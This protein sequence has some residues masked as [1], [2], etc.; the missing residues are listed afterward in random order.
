[1]VN[2]YSTHLRSSRFV[3]GALLVLAM[4]VMTMPPAQAAP[5]EFKERYSFEDP[6]HKDDFLSDV[7]GTDIYASASGKGTVKFYENGRI[8]DHFN[9]T[10][11]HWNPATGDVVIRQEA[12]TFRGM[13]V[14]VFDPETMTV[15]IT[16]E[17]TFTGLPSKWM[18]PGEGLLW[19]D[20]GKVTFAGTIVLDVSGDEPELI[21]FD[22]TVD[23]K[24]PHPELTEDFEVLVGIL[25]GALGA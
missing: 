3:I 15:T 14:E 10:T 4:V 22:E 8:V 24:G 19:R 23:I 17:D 5:P 21:S 18:K 11:K 16:F 2:P 9:V 6:A 7:C 12:A 13:G 25:C 20:A 1:M